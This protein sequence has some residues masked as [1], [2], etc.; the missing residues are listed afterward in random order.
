[1][2]SSPRKDQATEKSNAFVKIGHSRW[3]RNIPI[4][5]G[6]DGPID[7][8]YQYDDPCRDSAWDQVSANKSSQGHH[9]QGE[10]VTRVQSFT[11]LASSPT[12]S[13]DSPSLENGT[14]FAP[15][16]IAKG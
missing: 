10:K 16:Q 8:N 5:Y 6:K 11:K 13:N 9:G 4:H 12:A 14:V 7:F 3:N 15:P 1:M 2:N